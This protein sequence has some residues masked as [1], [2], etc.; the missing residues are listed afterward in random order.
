MNELNSADAAPESPVNPICTA[1]KIIQKE[2]L[3]AGV[4]FLVTHNIPIPVIAKL[5]IERRIRDPVLDEKKPP[6]GSEA[7]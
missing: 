2:G 7:R 6:P 3:Q 1:E 5:L 4:A